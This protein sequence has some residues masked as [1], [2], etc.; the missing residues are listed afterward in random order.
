LWFSG[1]SDWWQVLQVDSVWQSQQLSAVT[2]EC[3]RTVCPWMRFQFDWWLGGGQVSRISLWH[4]AHS[5]A[6]CFSAWHSVHA[7]M[8]GDFRL[9]TCSFD[10]IPR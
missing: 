3:A 1:F 10:S 5:D 4:V 9:E 6:A 2:S 7:A 8:F